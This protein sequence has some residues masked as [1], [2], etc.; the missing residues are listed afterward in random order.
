MPWWL[1]GA[2]TGL[3]AL[4]CGGWQVFTWLKFGYWPDY[5]LRDLMEQPVRK[6]WVG[7][8]EIFYRFGRWPV[9]LAGF[10]AS[11][12]LFIVGNEEAER[13]NY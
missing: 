11:W 10:L 13:K 7:L 3:F 8:N 12:G 6:K 4:A 5:D 2:A 9:W 1:A